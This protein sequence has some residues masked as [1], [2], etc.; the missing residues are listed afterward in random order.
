MTVPARIPQ[1]EIDRA[2]KVAMKAGAG[3]ARVRLDYANACIDIILGEPEPVPVPVL[4][5]VW[6]DDD[7]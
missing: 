6:G 1:A 5:H 7:V 3:R 4:P 2:V